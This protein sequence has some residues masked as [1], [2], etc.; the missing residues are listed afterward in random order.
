MTAAE[1]SPGPWWRQQ[2]QRFDALG[3][4]ERL[5]VITAAAAACVMAA[6][7]LW[8]TPAFKAWSAVHKR[9]AALPG[10]LAK[11]AAE[12][13]RNA[14]AALAQERQLQAEL[15]QLRHR[16]QDGEAAMHE[17]EANLVGPDRMLALLEQMLDGHGQLRVR[18]MKSLPRT[19]LVAEA[20]SKVPGPAG[21]APA[22]RPALYRHGIEL[23]LEGSFADL[24]RYL[25]ALEN[26]PQRLLW[27]A[28][29]LKVEQHPK[30]LLTL[31]VYTLSLDRHWLEI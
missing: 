27:G 26:M 7:A 6:D 13:Q 5:L 24:V 18:E 15:A 16:L 20:A 2:R 4:R 9:E 11:T 17:I 25:E 12:A 31:R 19:D 28:M 21:S 10:V 23:T 3:R 8:I 1:R 14:E 30:A 22:E 29:Q